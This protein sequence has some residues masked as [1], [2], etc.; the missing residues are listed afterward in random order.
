ML[1]IKKYIFLQLAFKV[2]TISQSTYIKIF[3]EAY[4]K[5]IEF[6]TQNRKKKKQKNQAVGRKYRLIFKAYRTK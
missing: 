5:D 3:Y 6:K 4:R 1:F 2:R